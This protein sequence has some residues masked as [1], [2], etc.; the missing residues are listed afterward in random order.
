MKLSG[1]LSGVQVIDLSRLLP[2][3]YC[4]MILADHAPMSFRWGTSIVDWTD[5][6]LPP[7]TGI[8]NTLP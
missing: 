1:A 5:T 6:R 2:G 4:S 3:P 7:S 8:K